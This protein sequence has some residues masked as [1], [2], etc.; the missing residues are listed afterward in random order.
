MPLLA[1]MKRNWAV[2]SM[3][4]T[5]FVLISI[6]SN[7]PNW[8]D[9][10]A[11]WAAAMKVYSLIVLGMVSA[12]AGA[13]E[14]G[15]LRR[16]GRVDYPSRRS[17]LVR[18][19][20][21]IVISWLPT[22]TLLVLA[23]V[24]AGGMSAVSVWAPAEVS[25]FAWTCV[26]F[27]LGVSLRLVVA[28][29]A[30]LILAFGW[31]ALT[32]AM[33][34]PVVRHLPA[35]WDG[36]CSLAEVPSGSVMWGSLLM[37]TTLVFASGLVMR[38]ASIG[39]RVRGASIAALVLVAGLMSSMAL[40]RDVGYFPTQRR[41]ADMLCVGTMPTTCFWPEREPRL[42]QASNQV[43][44]VTDIWR[45]RGVALPGTLSEAT[46][47]TPQPGVGRLIYASNASPVQRVEWLADG[48]VTICP[49]DELTALPLEPITVRD[50]LVR[51]TEIS[52]PPVNQPELV[53]LVSL[54]MDA[55]VAQI[56]AYLTQVR[57]C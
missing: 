57:R 11:P 55:Q 49:Y 52:M 35:T 1:L 56:N 54:P 42:T 38:A 16:I 41:H 32:P 25:L 10:Y 29:P 47:A 21:H 15:W 45:D 9:G 48:V 26:G 4:L 40:V 13:A 22:A 36:C 5:A 34:P 51:Q 43:H 7:Q 33:E 28:L 37:S 8:Y 46:S 39:R 19:G 17:D 2:W 20:I 18:F 50:W 23:V 30:S 14:G 24:A 44:A 31:F 3:P 53:T 6:K 27:A 12:L